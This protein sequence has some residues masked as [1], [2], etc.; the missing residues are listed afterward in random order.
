MHTY[1]LRLVACGGRSLRPP[2]PLLN[3]RNKH[4]AT[5]T[6]QGAFINYRLSKVPLPVVI[7]RSKDC[8]YSYVHVCTL[9]VSRR[10]DDRCQDIRS[11]GQGSNSKPRGNGKVGTNRH[12]TRPQDRCFN[13]T[14]LD[15][16][17]NSLAGSF[18]LVS[19]IRIRISTV[20]GMAWHGMEWRVSRLIVV[21]PAGPDRSNRHKERPCHPGTRGK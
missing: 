17:T 4:R 5:E 13:S 2:P 19:A 7:G 10:I 14:C 21:L 9:Y 6:P 8:A 1:R 20:Q 18:S 3:P 16:T 15:S 12:E 11:P